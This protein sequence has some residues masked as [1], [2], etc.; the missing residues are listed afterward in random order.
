MYYLIS[1]I[2]D[3]CTSNPCLNGG[4]CIGIGFGGFSCQ[5]PAGY[6]G[7]RCEDQDV[8]ASAPCQNGGECTSNG[9]G[10]YECRCPTGFEGANCEQGESITFGMM[11]YQTFVHPVVDICGVKNPCICGTCQ[12]DANSPQG[13]RCFCPP[14]YT[15]VRC[16]T[17]PH[18]H[19]CAKDFKVSMQ[20]FIAYV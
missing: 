1:T 6:S 2:A 11:N 5:C 14:G 15:G 13:F 16:E 12:N 7:Q 8:C 18:I 10:S 9:A 19:D 4:T 3:P 17:G 20:C